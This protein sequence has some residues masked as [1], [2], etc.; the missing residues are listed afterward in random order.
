MALPSEGATQAPL[1][2]IIDTALPNNY[3]VARVD[4]LVVFVPEAIIG[5]IVKVRILRRE[6]RVA[7][8]EIAEIVA[9]SPFRV[10][11][12]CPHFGPCGGCAFQNLAYE[13]QLELKENYLLQTL[14]RI[15]GLDMKNIR[16]FP[17]ISSPDTYFYR[18]KIELAF[19]ENKGGITMGLRERVSPFKSYKGNVIPIERCLISSPVTEKIIPIFTA[20]ARE[21]SLKAYNTFTGSGF[22]RHL[23]LRE[24]KS[25]GELMAVLETT[26]GIIPDLI[27]LWESLNILI[28]EIKSFYTIINSRP[29]DDFHSGKLKH[30]AGKLYIDETLNDFRFSIF[31]GSFFQPNSGSAEIL[32]KKLIELTRLNANE[33]VLGL[34]CGAGPIEICLSGSAKEVTGIDSLHSNI[35]NAK[36]NCRLNNVKNCLFYEGKIETVL[37]K[38]SL[39][40]TDLLIMDPPRGGISKDGLKHVFRINP[41]K[42]AYV[43]CNPSTLARDLKDILMHGYSINDIAP[44]DFFPHTTHIETLVIMNRS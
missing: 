42:I 40:E 19:G 25:S 30:I 1:I 15:G 34:Y 21:H 16:I 44:F 36:E 10:M 11:P 18:N 3:G 29:G 32:Y 4:G 22:L 28:P 38:I 43:S 24:S 14:K 35:M 6:K 37:S 5:D 31:P 27:P 23:I 33:N 39:V 41:K 2:E 20:F 17:I 12:R 13:K 7:Y 9:P 8:G 26:E